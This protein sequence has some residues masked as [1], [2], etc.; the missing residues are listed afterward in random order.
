ML[1]N[2]ENMTRG[3]KKK[4]HSQTKKMVLNKMESISLDIRHRRFSP[5][6]HES[7]LTVKCVIAFARSFV[8]LKKNVCFHSNDETEISLFKF[9][10]K[11]APMFQAEHLIYRREKEREIGSGRF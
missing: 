10:G 2:I 7:K 5:S 8:P 1:Y 11:Y 9:K 6:N 3:E 4:K